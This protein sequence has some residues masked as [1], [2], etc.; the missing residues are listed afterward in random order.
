MGDERLA[1]FPPRTVDKVERLLDLLVEMGEH[2]LLR[3]KLAL[4]GGT[5]L[6]LFML[7]IPRL[8]VDIDVSYIGALDRDEMFAE[9]P[10]ILGYF[11]DVFTDDMHVWRKFLCSMC[12]NRHGAA[13]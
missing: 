11:T 13:A 8:S 9:R 5:A 4:H 12:V 10:L 3:G 2:P 7:D 1:G 6:N